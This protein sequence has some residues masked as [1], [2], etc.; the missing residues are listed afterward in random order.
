MRAVRTG[1]RRPEGGACRA[2]AGGC[3]RL[4][5]LAIAPARATTHARVIT[6]AIVRA[7]ATTHARVLTIAFILTGS[8]AIV[9]TLTIAIARAITLARPL[10]LAFTLIL[11]CADPRSRARRAQFTPLDACPDGA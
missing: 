6:I 11:T 5:A 8:I 2:V 9:F 3:G 4:C 1:K 10:A 7:R